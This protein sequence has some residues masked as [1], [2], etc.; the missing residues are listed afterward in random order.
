MCDSEKPIMH[1]NAFSNAVL[2]GIK[3]LDFCSRIRCLFFTACFCFLL[4]GIGV[5]IGLYLQGEFWW[6]RGISDLW[7]ECTVCDV[8]R[9]R[10]K[11]RVLIP[12][13]IFL[14]RKTAICRAVYVLFKLSC[15]D[16]TTLVGS[17]LIS[18]IVR[19]AGWR[20]YQC[21]ILEFSIKHRWKKFM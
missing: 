21:N 13:P 9:R 6:P 4:V 10:R 20:W 5:C 14:N 1:F 18:T 11:R 15:E 17:Q 8:E 3:L 16:K 2:R 19:L 12:Q 7:S